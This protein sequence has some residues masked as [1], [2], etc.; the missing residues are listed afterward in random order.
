VSSSFGLHSRR[1]V[2]LLIEM[3][4]V[5]HHEHCP[6]SGNAF[7]SRCDESTARAAYQGCEGD[8]LKY[9]TSDRVD[10]QR[11]LPINRLYDSK[12]SWA[13]LPRRWGLEA[14]HSLPLPVRVL[15]ALVAAE[16]LRS[17]KPSAAHTVGTAK[18]QRT[19]RTL[20]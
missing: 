14:T 6:Y 13:C 2:G 15:V 11:K 16:N 3:A 1:V 9:C 19:T 10:G 17:A 20:A 7:D 12:S 18:G 5:V 8:T 4:I